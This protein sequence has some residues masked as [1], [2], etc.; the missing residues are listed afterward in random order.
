MH[1]RKS[2]ILNHVVNVIHS[3]IMAVTDIACVHRNINHSYVRKS[4]NITIM[5][6]IQLLL[7]Y[8]GR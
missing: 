6:Y 5:L 4:Y 7:Y 2:H 3:I 8:I 1:F